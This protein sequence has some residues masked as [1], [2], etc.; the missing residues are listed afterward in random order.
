M[1]EEGRHI[2]WQSLA[3]PGL[4][5]VRIRSEGDQLVAHGRT[6]RVLGGILEDLRW[7]VECDP[8]WRT[9]A[10]R[11][12]IKDR[13]HPLLCAE[14]DGQGRWIVQAGEVRG[15]L[16][17]CVDVDLAVTPFTNTLP[18]RRLEPW[19]VGEEVRVRVAVAD[20]LEG[21]FLPV[22]QSYTLE[23]RRGDVRIF[24]YRN[25]DTGYEAELSVDPSGF[26]IDYANEF[27][28]A[29]SG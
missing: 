11:A 3:S 26:V 29:W 25:L 1:N 20:P 19:R 9:R 12:L 10:V 4:E 13:L 15:R 22:R 24:G 8:A 18:I 5:H 27:R 2:V 28:R 23:A 6:V 17:G 16:A 21:A 14:C 7:R